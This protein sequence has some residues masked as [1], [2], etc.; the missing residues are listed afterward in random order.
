MDWQKDNRD[1]Y[2]DTT[3]GTAVAIAGQ[4][5]KPHAQCLEKWYFTDKDKATSDILEA[6]QANGNY[7]P[8]LI[9]LAM[10]QKNCGTFKYRK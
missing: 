5:D 6:M 4:N 8:R 10:L 1:F 3:V 2:L 9:I 7:H